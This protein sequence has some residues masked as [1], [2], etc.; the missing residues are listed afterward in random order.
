MTI[1]LGIGRLTKFWV[2]VF[3]EGLGT[4][5]NYTKLAG[6]HVL[7]TGVLL[8]LLAYH[9]PIIWVKV[10]SSHMYPWYRYSVNQI[11][12]LW[13]RPAYRCHV[14]NSIN[15]TSWQPRPWYGCYV[16]KITSLQVCSLYGC[17]ITKITSLQVARPSYECHVV[18]MTSSQACTICKGIMLLK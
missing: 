8:R 7:R 10:T 4:I 3:V 6:W 5:Q 1:V 12:S 13:S 16:V 18:K 2:F 15:I 9:P 17:Y 14:I 11:A